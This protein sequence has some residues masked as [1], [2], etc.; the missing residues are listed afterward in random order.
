MQ[1]DNIFID[2]RWVKSHGTE[3]IEVVDP[4][5]ETV[6]GTVPAGTEADVDAAVSAARSALDSWSATPVAERCRFLTRIADGLK[7]RAESLAEL[8][9]A[10]LGSPLS[11]SRQVQ[12]GFPVASFREAAEVATGFDWEEEIGHSTVVREPIGVVGA[13]TPW[14]YPLHQI[15]AKVAYALAAGN[16]V[17]LKPSEVVPL[18]A[19][20]LAE[21]IEE[22]GLPAGVFNLVSG[23]GSTVGHAL[24]AHPDVDMISF[25]GSTEAGK[26][27]SEAAAVNV[28]RVA[29]ELGGKSP[30]I[31][32][33]GVD[34]PTAMPR[35]VRSAMAN[36]GQT[37]SALTRLVV[38]EHLLAE[39]ERLAKVEADSLVVGDPG[40]EDTALGPLVSRT[41]LERVLDYIKLGTTEGA[42]LVTGGADPVEGIDT[43]YYVRPTVFSDVTPEMTIRNEEIFGP[44]LVIETYRT[45]DEAVA[46]AND[47]PYGLA[48]GIWSADADSARKLS[49]RIRAGQISIN[50]ARTNLRAPFGGYKQSGNGREYG[51][52][53]FEEFLETKSIQN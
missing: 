17:V 28:K 42:R 43:G 47:T 38:P 26:R 40:S 36:S 8:I 12:V 21:V 51:R 29:V 1:K 41:Q 23:T 2:G 4:A 31:V 18:N 53:G 30:N 49:R 14:N 52:F 7:Q 27:V 20:V 16:T 6:I 22:A 9:T 32:L 19:W 11:M 35:I 3:T 24:A 50:G 25:T 15:A 13:I 48:A 44:V 39:V 33:D 34:L 37:C 10:E 5:R 46:I 45:V